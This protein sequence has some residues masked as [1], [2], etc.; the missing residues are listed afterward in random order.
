M[1]EMLRLAVTGAKRNR[2]HVGICG[3]APA[4]YPEI[5]QFLAGLGI[6]SISVNA[7]SLLRT[8][9]RRARGRAAGGTSRAAGC[10]ITPNRESAMMAA[11]VTLTMNPALD[12]ATSTDRVVPTHKLRCAA[13]RYDPGGGGINVARAVHAL[14]G[15]AVAIFP[16]GGAAGEMI[17]HLLDSRKASTTMRS[18]SP[19]SPAR[20]SPSRSDERQPISVHLA[21]T[22]IVAKRPGTLSRP[23]LSGGCRGRNTLSP[24]AACR[25]GFPPIF[26][27]ARPSLRAPEGR[28]S[29]SI[30]RA[31][32]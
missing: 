14:G 10:E 26:M 16:V 5:A 18:R 29:S 24:A 13:P 6:D 11:I 9:S 2:R 27:R 22:G 1:L 28:I 8:I 21:G 25:R 17:R 23:T 32:R 20:A 31:R 7:A 19:A 4:N 12:I 15:D 30:P 3:E